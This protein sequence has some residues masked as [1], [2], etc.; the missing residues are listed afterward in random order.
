MFMLYRPPDAPSIEEALAADVKE[1][2]D[3]YEAKKWDLAQMCWDLIRIKR[4]HYFQIGW[5]DKDQNIS[6]RVMIQCRQMFVMGC[7]LAIL[8]QDFKDFHHLLNLLSNLNGNVDNVGNSRETSGILLLGLVAHQDH[9]GFHKEL[10]RLS[11]EDKKDPNVV[12]AIRLSNSLTEG[13]LQEALELCDNVVSGPFAATFVP[14]LVSIIRAEQVKCMT[15]AYKKMKVKVAMESLHVKSFEEFQMFAEK[16]GWGLQ[17]VENACPMYVTFQK[18]EE[19]T[20]P[21]V[22]I[23]NAMFDIAQSM[24]KIE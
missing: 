23:D 19:P 24:N 21:T 15:T 8:R 12:G 14:H 17:C 1:L 10:Q 18:S 20:K 22:Q 6:K 5:Q 11:E 9:Q 16:Q 4:S 7:K 3:F 2:S 13:K